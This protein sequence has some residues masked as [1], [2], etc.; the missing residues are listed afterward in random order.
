MLT[1]FVGTM[2]PMARQLCHDATGHIACLR[3]N[4][5]LH[6]KNQVIYHREGFGYYP[7]LW[8]DN[9]VLKPSGKKRPY[10]DPTSFSIHISDVE[11]DCKSLKGLLKLS[12]EFTHFMVDYEGGDDK[13]KNLK[14]RLGKVKLARPFIDTT[15]AIASE[16]LPNVGL[17]N[18][19]H[20]GVN[21]YQHYICAYHAYSL[22]PLSGSTLDSLGYAS[23]WDDIILLSMRLDTAWSG[24]TVNHNKPIN[25]EQLSY[26]RN[27]MMQRKTAMWGVANNTQEALALHSDWKKLNN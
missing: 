18:S 23:N 6:T 10:I 22:A 14:E 12:N 7:N 25:E 9:G 13:Y 20:Y 21:G 3:E 26:Y 27:N 11:I 15:L 2:A 19:R 4:Q 1:C 24:D 17:Y 5:G 8:N 16:Y